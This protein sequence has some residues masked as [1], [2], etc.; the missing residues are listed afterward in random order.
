MAQHIDLGRK[1]EEAAAEFLTGNGFSIRE[2]NWKT[3]FGEIDI[4]AETS[5]FLVIVEVKTRSSVSFGNPEEAV[6]LRKQKLLVN[7]ADSYI[8]RYDIEK[9]T[10]FDIV[11]V[12]MGAGG[13][14]VTHHPFAFSPFD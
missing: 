2:K 13:F 11:S 5:E 12:V 9:E 1:G 6:N 4:I 8:R 14:T 3:N 7:M 10:R